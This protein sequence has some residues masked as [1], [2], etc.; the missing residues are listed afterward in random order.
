MRFSVLAGATKRILEKEDF[1]LYGYGGIGMGDYLDEFA[2]EAGIINV[3]RN[4]FYL[5]LG[6]C[7]PEY[8]VDLTLGIGVVF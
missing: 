8:Y 2:I 1:R 4:R 5:S 6:A 7:V 3:I